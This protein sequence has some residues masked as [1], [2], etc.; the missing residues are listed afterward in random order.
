MG[1]QGQGHG[2]NT[3]ITESGKFCFKRSSFLLIEFR[4]TEMCSSLNVTKVKHY[5]SKQ[6]GEHE[7]NA[8]V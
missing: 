5:I 2:E 6:S 1:H 3:I 7:E 4:M 8:T